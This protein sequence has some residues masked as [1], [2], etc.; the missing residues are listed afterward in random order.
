[1]PPGRD[2]RQPAKICQFDAQA[3]LKAAA[4]VLQSRSTRLVS[5]HVESFRLAWRREVARDE[6][7]LGIAR[8]EFVSARCV[9]ITE[10]RFTDFIGH[11]ELVELVTRTGTL[12]N[13]THPVPIGYRVGRKV[14]GDG[15][16]STQQ[17]FDM[18]PRR[19][20]QPRGP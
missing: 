9:P 1:M 17:A 12:E 5:N 19:V 3:F 8:G 16:S 20:A 4:R 11:F 7:E 2:R 6:L 18:R 14:Q 10:P 15:N 13:A